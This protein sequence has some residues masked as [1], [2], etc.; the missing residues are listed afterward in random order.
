MIGEQIE[1]VKIEY[2]TNF[3]DQMMEYGKKYSFL[4]LEN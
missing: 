4:P 2:P 3:Y 1:D